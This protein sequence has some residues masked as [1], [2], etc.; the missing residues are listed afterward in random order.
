MSTFFDSITGVLFST[1]GG[2]APTAGSPLTVQNGD[3][4]TS[5]GTWMGSVSS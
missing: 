5:Q 3:G 2:N 4:T 1:N